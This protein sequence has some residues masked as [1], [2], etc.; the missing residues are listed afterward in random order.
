MGSLKRKNK[1]TVIIFAAGVGRR[2]GKFGKE[3]PKCLLKVNDTLILETIIKKIKKM[4]FDKINIILGYKYKLILNFLRKKKLIKFNYIKKNNFKKN[5][6][7]FT[8]YSFKEIWRKDKNS[9]IFLHSDII[10]DFSFFKNI[11]N[12]RK[13]NIIGIKSTKNHVLK[14]NSFLVTANKNNCVSSISQKKNKKFFPQGEILGINKFSKK[15]TENLFNYMDTFFDKNNKK[16][17]WE[18]VLN[19][20]IQL[21]LD[22]FYIL[23]KQCYNWININEHVDLL[24]AQ[25]IKF[26]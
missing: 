14:K 15:T 4:G 2:L 11:V 9:I 6:H 13:P 26:K 7:A 21:K 3:K 20:Y 1:P 8:L 5:G 10:F 16:L 25:K 18:N 23:K 22:K 24:K 12:S 17:S 19:K